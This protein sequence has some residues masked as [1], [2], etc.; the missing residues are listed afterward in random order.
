LG[1]GAFVTDLSWL[2]VPTGVLFA[3]GLAGVGLSLLRP[4]ARHV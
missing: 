3:F 4:A 1:F 2:L